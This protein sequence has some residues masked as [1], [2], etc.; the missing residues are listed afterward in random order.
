MY[1][2]NVISQLKKNSQISN[3]ISLF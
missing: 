3:K 1:K 2:L